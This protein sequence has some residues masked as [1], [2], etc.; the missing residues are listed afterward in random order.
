MKRLQEKFSYLFTADRKGECITF[1]KLSQLA[2][3]KWITF[4][5][6]FQVLGKQVD[7]DNLVFFDRIEEGAF[8]EFHYHPDADETI[9]VITGSILFNDLVRLN[10][11][12]RRFIN[13]NTDHKVE[14][15]EYTELIVTIKRVD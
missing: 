12:D 4:N 9:E 5:E 11:D 6:G 3:G 1:D 15:L 7:N 14:A 8:L 2:T 10:K 13:K